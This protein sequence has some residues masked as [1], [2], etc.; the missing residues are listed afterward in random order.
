LSYANPPSSILVIDDTFAN[1]RLLTELLSKKG[2]SVRPVA[3][4]ALALVSAQAE[5][6]D[7][8]LLDIM[9]PKLSGYDVCQQLKA[10]PR[11]RDVPVIFMSAL[12][13]VIDKVKAFS[14]GGI[15]Y[16]TKP[17]QA[18][19]VLARVETHLTL[20]HSQKRLREQN[21]QLQQEIQE[22][23]RTEA[24]LQQRNREL[25]SLNRIS[26]MFGSSLEL[27]QVLK[28]ALGEIQRLRDVFS[29]SFWLISPE[30]HEILCTQ[31]IGHG[32]ET[33]VTCHLALGQGITGWVA[34]HGE[35]Q[36][37][38]DVL[39]D[40]RHVRFIDERT[41]VEVRSMVSLPL[42]VKGL[43]TGVLNLVDQR[44]DHFTDD[45]IL[46]LEPIAAAAAIA[47]ENA[48]LYTTAQQEIAERKHAEMALLSAHDD[49]KATVEHLQRT[50]AQLIESE[51]MA[52]LGQLVAGIAHEIN[53]PLGAIQASIENIDSILEDRL[54]DLP[55][56]LLSLSEDDRHAFFALQKQAMHKDSMLSSR[57]ERRLKQAIRAF[58][59]EHH[60]ENTWKTSEILM[61]LGV[62]DHI[63]PFI[64]L[65]KKPEHELVLH[66]AY[67]FAG[68]HESTQTIMTAVER[69]S[70]VVFALKSYVHYDH[71]GEMVQ[72]D[73]T[74]GI[75]TALTLYHNHFKHGIEVIRQ[76]QEISQIF[77]YPDELTQVWA[78]LIHNALQAMENKGTL[79]IEVTQH[80][81]ASITVSITDSGCGISEDVRE[82][83]FEPFFTT[84]PSGEGSGLGLDIVKKI[85][86]KHH[87]KIDT[88]SR[89]GKTT[90]R[91]NLPIHADSSQAQADVGSRQQDS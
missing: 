6:P 90:F 77:C 54:E 7:L 51:K 83:M 80:K 1:L 85:V 43:V 22:R 63:E 55:E 73:V 28:T 20:Q 30:E 12:H 47:I 4:G 66:A 88:E 25:S 76:Y 44:T 65:L 67:H 69:A 3:D 75:E 24:A 46:L 49:L 38:A 61:H 2:Y 71:T 58:L 59:D 52:A 37:V 9:M 36:V 78:N 82:R 74:K 62:Y 11:T 17:F 35:S 26:R 84:K 13:Q 57:E 53:S 40:E 29:L 68:L 50:Q 27:Q 16:I 86:D 31:A 79:A 18:E 45:D 10:T 72:A 34:Q 60:I 8:I 48:R 39:E 41:G 21:I 32:H 19:E 87:G 5:P 81:D 42:R 89:P 15:D 91:I 64:P 70:K 23:K 33:I 56:F 14:V